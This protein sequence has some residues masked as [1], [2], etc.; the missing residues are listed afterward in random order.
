MNYSLASVDFAEDWME[1]LPA[2]RRE[3]RR[4]AARLLQNDP[5]M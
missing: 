5:S 3:N 2:G 1:G 4:A